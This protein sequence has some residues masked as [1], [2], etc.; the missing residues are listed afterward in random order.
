M[1][2]MV[3]LVR[4][5]D[6]G[7]WLTGGGRADVVAQEWLDAGFTVDD[8]VGWWQAGCFYAQRT[9]KLRDAGLTPADV[10]AEDGNGE[11]LGYAYCEGDVSLEFVLTLKS[12]CSERQRSPAP[13]K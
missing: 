8:V 5:H 3:E 10:A 2:T 1:T 6:Q 4:E 7:F 12:W 13:R 11:T 9:K